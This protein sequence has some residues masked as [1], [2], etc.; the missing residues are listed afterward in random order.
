MPNFDLASEPVRQPGHPGPADAPP[1]GNA[2]GGASASA[3]ESVAL[4]ERLLESEQRLRGS[5]E[6]LRLATEVTGTG[7]WEL[8]FATGS[9]SHNDACL[10]MFG[11]REL[12]STVRYMSSTSSPRR[13]SLTPGKNVP[14]WKTSVVSVQ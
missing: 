7:V 3:T 14:S 8:D 2:A 12:A 1:A 10:A 6:L 11:I 4:T 5:Q 13:Q 9:I